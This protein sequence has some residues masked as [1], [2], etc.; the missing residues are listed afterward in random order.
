MPSTISAMDR[1]T[2]LAMSPGP[3]PNRTILAVLFLLLVPFVAVET[4]GVALFALVIHINASLTGVATLSQ[5]LMV[6]GLRAL[7]LFGYSRW[8]ESQRVIRINYSRTRMAVVAVAASI[9]LGFL[10]SNNFEIPSGYQPQVVRA[11]HYSIAHFGDIVGVTTTVAQYVY[12]AF[13][14]MLIVFLTDAFQALA[15]AN[16]LRQEVPWGGL[17]LALTWGLLHIR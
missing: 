7:S 9:P 16:A 12:Y 3:R 13:E 17:G 14:G 2:V 6:T 4:V 11:L 15:E 5:L 1:E 10:I 8:A